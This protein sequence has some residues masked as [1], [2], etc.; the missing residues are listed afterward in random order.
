MANARPGREAISDSQKSDV[1]CSR[2]RPGLPRSDPP[3]GPLR[4]INGDEWRGRSAM[5]CGANP[6]AQPAQRL[7]PG[8]ALSHSHS[9]HP[10]LSLHGGRQ[11]GKG[12]TK[13]WAAGEEQRIGGPSM[14]ISR[15]VRVN[16][17]CP[18]PQTQISTTRIP[19]VPRIWSA[20]RPRVA[21]ADPRRAAGLVS[22]WGERTGRHPRGLRSALARQHTVADH[23]VPGSSR[24]PGPAEPGPSTA[25]CQC[26][27]RSQAQ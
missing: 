6:P 9:L 14:N 26:R 24:A 20:G 5:A 23:L 1:D 27:A 11:A 7:R 18:A 21:D 16:M 3:P 4:A 19:D 25:A 2:R 12:V 15:M 22:L 17:A 13:E 8:A 10:T